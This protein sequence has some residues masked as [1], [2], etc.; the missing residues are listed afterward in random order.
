MKHKNKLKTRV[1]KTYSI[2]T[3][4]SYNSLIIGKSRKQ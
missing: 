4:F 3:R 1:E 2:I